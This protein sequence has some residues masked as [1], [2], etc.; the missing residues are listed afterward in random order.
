MFYRGTVGKGKW[1]RVHRQE[2]E[3]LANI[4]SVRLHCDRQPFISAS[5]LANYA[6]S[7]AAPDVFEKA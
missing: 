5:K 6:V 1:V 2:E 4:S 3:V 7:A